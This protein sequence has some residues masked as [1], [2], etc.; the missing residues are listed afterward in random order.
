MRVAVIA[1]VHANLPA[2]EAVLEAAAAA[3]VERVVCLGDIVGYNAEPAACIERLQRAAQV[4]VAG[5]HDVDTAHQTHGAGTSAPARRV[6]DWTRQ[7]LPAEAMTFL[8]ALPTLVVDSAGFVAVHGCFLNSVYYSGYVTGTMLAT[9]LAA[10]AAR[11][12]WPKLALCGH[13]HI[14]MCGWLTADGCVEPR[15]DGLVRWARDAQAVLVN[16]GSVGQPRDGDP[17]AAFAVVDLV[18]QTAEVRRVRYDVDR[19]TRA[20]REAGL[21]EQLAERLREGR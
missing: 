2:L 3:G 20:I 4:V 18:G 8:A 21:P 19:A 17:R 15:F 5:N 6:Q 14:P 9:N 1:D 13:T 10:V 7:Q 12:E 16:P 11:S